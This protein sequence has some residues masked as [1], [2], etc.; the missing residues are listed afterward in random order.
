MV[1]GIY[2]DIKF[3]SGSPTPFIEKIDSKILILF[4]VSKR[5]KS[6]S[7]R[8]QVKTPSIFFQLSPNLKSILRL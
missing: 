6:V 5:E 3:I 2:C 1:S 8:P 7:H 4:Q